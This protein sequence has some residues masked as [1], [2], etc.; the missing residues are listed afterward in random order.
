MTPQRDISPENL[1]PMVEGLLLEQ[2]GTWLSSEELWKLLHAAHPQ[3]AERV[4]QGVAGDKDSVR[5]NALR[6]VSDTL[7]R[8]EGPEFEAADADKVPDMNGAAPWLVARA[9]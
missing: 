8:L 1:L 9:V 7:A 6:F 5:S 3:T 2:R 4:Q